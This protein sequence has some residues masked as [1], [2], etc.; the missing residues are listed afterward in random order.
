MSPWVIQTLFQ[1]LMVDLIDKA[2]QFKVT[3]LDSEIGRQFF[4]KLKEYFS[5]D[6]ISTK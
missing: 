2:E 4:E 1:Q 5:V 3:D 6:E